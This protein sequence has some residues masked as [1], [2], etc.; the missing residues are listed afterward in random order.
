MSW[1]DIL[2]I[3]IGMFIGA[4]LGGIAF[5]TRKARREDDGKDTD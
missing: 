2:A 4:Y 5:D 1:V 3:W